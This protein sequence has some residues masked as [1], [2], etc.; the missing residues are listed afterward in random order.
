MNCPE[1]RSEL[2]SV[3]KPSTSVLVPA[4]THENDGLFI[5]DLNVLK[6][7]ILHRYRIILVWACFTVFSNT[8]Y[9]F[10]EIVNRKWIVEEAADSQSSSSY[11]H[12]LEGM[13]FSA[14]LFKSCFAV[15]DSLLTWSTLNGNFQWKSC[16]RD[17]AGNIVESHR[18]WLGAKS[19]IRRTGSIGR[20]NIRFTCKVLNVRGGCSE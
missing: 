8:C 10:K 17:E 4:A 2:L 5:E 14:L 16:W 1:F 6:T 7:N 20:I 15:K 13:N 3:F 18:I 19:S 12:C 11:K 9:P